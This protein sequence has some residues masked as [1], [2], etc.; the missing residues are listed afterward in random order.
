MTFDEIIKQIVSSAGVTEEQAKKSVA[1]TTLG[2]KENLPDA[3]AAQIDEVMVGEKFSYQE[4]LGDKF[5]EWKDRLG[6][7]LKDWKDGAAGLIDK[8]F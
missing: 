6:D 7:K 2:L 1:I 4:A 8:V 3:I 5:G